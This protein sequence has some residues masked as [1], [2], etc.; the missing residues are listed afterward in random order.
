MTP[1]DY[2]HT[3]RS[4]AWIPPFRHEARGGASTLAGMSEL[5][6]SMSGPVPEPQGD[7]V[8]L[9]PPGAAP[10]HA[11][12]YGAP[13]A[14]AYPPPPG[15]ASPG[16]Y[17]PPSDDGGIPLWALGA[18][19]ALVVALL[20]ATVYL[21]LPTGSSP[22][23]RAYPDVW[24]P[25]IAP[26]VKVAE[27]QRGLTFQHPVE[28]HFLSAKEFEKTVTTDDAELTDDDRAEIDRMTGQMRALGLLTGDVDLAEAMN[29][30]QG[31]GILAYYSLEDETITVKGTK[32]RPEVR[33]TLVHELV[34]VLQDQH[35]SLGAAYARLQGDED[36]PDS[37]ASSVLRAIAEGDA[38]RIEA[39]YRESLSKKER[40]KLDRGR[41]KEGTKAGKRLDK[42][43]QVLVTLL[44]SPYALGSALVAA[45]AAD[46]GNRAVDD[47]L[48]DPPEHDLALLRPL[49]ALTGAAS[50]AEV[51][52]PSTKKDEEEYS[53]GELGA[54]TW[55]LML[56]ERMSPTRALSVVDGWGGDA[57][58]AFDRDGTSCVRA[59]YAG[60]AGEDAASMLRALKRWS[61]AAPEAGTKV[62]RDGDRVALST[63]DPGTKASVGTDSS[64]EALE[65]AMTRAY[66]GVTIVK[67][68]V[69][70]DVAACISDRLAEIYP[71]SSL[72]DPSF[73]AAD[74]AVQQRVRSV[75]TAC[76][77]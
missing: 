60:R 50:V 41:S 43:P 46:G 59:T 73:G 61:R 30:A 23:E 66:V 20:G 4:A 64:A 7:P 10:G 27:K 37:T 74:P 32:V 5:G 71:L 21:V 26:Y 8:P 54:L 31:G 68:G 52:L 76:R 67:S 11:P 15:Y 1:S 33:S 28:V 39:K 3:P 2:G 49:D 69:E 77:R 19:F 16:G 58:V 38:E 40:A 51:A 62:R 70:S 44:S 45:A 75:A 24:D 25:R 55:Y 72:R 17:R 14:A 12:A 18:L 34:H 13:G 36:A 9:P 48:R 22:D 42:V 56:A 6:G 53:S 47:L 57:Y 63:C 29:D 35:F 65:L